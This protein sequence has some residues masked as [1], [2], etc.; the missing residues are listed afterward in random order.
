M[1]HLQDKENVSSVQ[2]NLICALDS[3][4][5]RSV[6]QGIA[7][8]LSAVSMLG[9]VSRGRHVAM[10]R[11][12]VLLNLLKQKKANPYELFALR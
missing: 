1:R 2:R 8:G 10:V 7:A 6:I 11:A 9:T 12:H 5:L 4:D 3:S